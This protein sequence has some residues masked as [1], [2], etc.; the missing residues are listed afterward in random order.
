MAPD[1]HSPPAGTAAPSP[2]ARLHALEHRVEAAVEQAIEA[3]E[4]SLA[5]RFGA[6]CVRSLHLALKT[7]FI[8]LVVAYFVFG[9]LLLGTRYLLMPRVDELR[10]W[11]EREASR[12]LGA[13]LTVGRIDA[14]W[15][16][17]NPRL[18]LRDLRLT[19]RGGEAQLALPQVD[20]E[21]SWSSVARASLRFASL[22]VVAPELEV[23]RLGPAR[24]S[25]AGFVVEPQA[26]PAADESP[27]LD[28]V[29]GQGRIGVRDA[30]VVYIDEM[31]AAPG[32]PAPRYT[33][34][35]VRLTLIGGALSTRLALQARPPAALAGAID[36]RG[37]F[38]HRLF[39]RPADFAEWRGQLYVELDSADLAHAEQLARVLP[40]GMRI[41]RAQGALRTWADIDRGT[42][43][44]LTADVALAD[45][46]A[47]AGADLAPLE[48]EALRGRFT[49]RAWGNAF[50]GGQELRLE[51]FSLQGAGLALAP[52]DLRY[53]YTRGSEGEGATRDG[54]RPP[55]TEFE[56]SLI[57]LDM[58]TRLAAHVPLSPEL[59]QWIA[60]QDLR[61]RLSN[62]R[63]DFDGRIDA[64][65]RFALR[66]DF[67][68]LSSSAQAAAPP[69]DADGHARPGTPGFS[70]LAGMLEMTEAGGS[71]TLDA[72][73]ASLE[74]P[75]L[76]A[77]PR[78][79]FQRLAAQARFTRG[80]ERLDVQLHSL[81][82][83][84]ADLDLAAS[85][86]YQRALAAGSGP[87]RIDLT[88]RINRI[89]VAAVPRYLP[90][91]AG[92]KA[93]AW[94]GRALAGGRGSEGS[95]RLRG[96]L[97]DFPFR[98][99]RQGEF[100]AAV[101]VRD[102]RLD[103][104]P[105]APRE[106]GG[107]WPGWPALRQ[108]DADVVFE[109]QGLTVSARSATI[110][111]TRVLDAVARMPDLQQAGSAL[112]VSGSTSGPAADLLRFV[113]ES[114]LREPLRFIA[115]GSATGNARLDLRLDIP[116]GRTAEAAEVGVAG[117]IQLANNDIVLRE[118]ILPF[119]SASGR[120][121]FTRRTLT[122]AGISAGFAGGQLS[123]SALT[124]PDGTLVITGSGTATPA[125][126]GRQVDLPLVQRLLARAQGSARYSG[127]VTVRNG[128]ADLRFESDLGGWTV[129][130]PAPLAKRAGESL[131]LRVEL[132]GLGAE[133]DRVAVTA[134]NA[135]AVRLER[136]RSGAAV[137]VER[138]VIAVGEPA[139]LPE[140]GLMAQVNLPR[141]DFDAWQPLLEGPEA[142][143]G[144][145]AAG[146]P[147]AVAT[148]TQPDWLSLR[149]RELLIAGKPIANV[150]L[151]ATRLTEG[152]DTLWVANVTSDEINGALN[153]RSSAGSSTGRLSARLS[154]LVIP[155][156]QRTQVAQLLDAPPR[157]VPSIDVVADQFELGGKA[158]GRLELAA[159]NGGTPAQP[160]WTLMR[161]DLTAP[162]G[163]MSASGTWQR[164]AGQSGRTM[165]L[166]FG[167]DFSNA[168]A[169]L[170][171]LGIPDALRGGQGRLEGTL[172]WRGS[173]FAIHYPTLAG[174]LT[175]D[176]SKGQFLKASAGAGRLLGVLSLQSL[177]RRITLDFRDI[178]SE[179]FA[180][181]S[182]TASATVAGGVLSTRDL[183]MRGA[184]AN[185]LIEGSTDLGRETQNLHVLVLPEVNA[186]SASIA[187]ALLAN[188]AIGLGTFLA[189]M[190]LR[191]PLSKAFSFEYDITGTW[192]DPQVKRRERPEPEPPATTN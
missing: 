169:L 103:Y 29:L 56:A 12:V 3:T 109:R 88:A 35:E 100:R 130:L 186:G 171:R 86:S 82:A 145:R 147:T 77:Q 114:G 74:F 70:N 46:H 111:G 94:L 63:L 190:L 48:V 177:P 38:R 39:G 188:P 159:V 17:F 67:E 138:G 166:A 162:E 44:R 23:R 92:A 37:D 10:P 69:F 40:A 115:G 65:D 1:D 181:D 9:A 60:R 117:A 165:T 91:F 6:G 136:V 157:D 43:T 126:L 22:S 158:L 19:G 59:R 121:E 54:A 154:R 52:T 58:L 106:D 42:L 110:F 163:R 96:D 167:L 189:Q 160:V 164:A 116:L 170:A 144:A 150:V 73:D 55:R 41:E 84:N 137:A 76:F 155:E 20:A 107:E 99:P 95:L 176:T 11:L 66:T 101:R 26:G 184:S 7:T 105:P 161:L 134:G 192:A 75:G 71:L 15:R 191:D 128:I 175:L 113:R 25:I 8:G 87:G 156:G 27:L 178:F 129:D 131:P 31:Q 24:F 133:R 123:A 33:F 143:A 49:Q 102:G 13:Q 183:R 179:G 122:L 140:R 36:V 64:P 172:S 135:L 152:A 80:A 34:N 120:V 151:G 93:R 185:V 78:L 32:Q 132:T 53:R 18:T 57:S 168:G 30:Q 98:D 180:F 62:L 72:R 141:L 79:A 119:T 51:Q 187:Y 182:I 45:V 104:L 50:R 89:E 139:P 16:G 47:V 148:G 173:P 81:A 90:L 127:N 61:G 125:A 21:V 149:A 5:Q 68:A 2:G 97:H 4:R 112:T 14:G 153:W 146:R 174:Q 83:S 108:I 142:P 118:D 124:R 28:W 85:G